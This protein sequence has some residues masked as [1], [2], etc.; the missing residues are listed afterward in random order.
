MC[1]RFYLNL[2]QEG[3]EQVCVPAAATA[4]L[5]A[6]DPH[7]PAAC[8]LKFVYWIFM[9]QAFL[10]AHLLKRTMSAPHQ[11]P[12]RFPLLSGLCLDMHATTSTQDPKQPL[13]DRPLSAA[14]NKSPQKV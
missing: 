7:L 5:A 14:Q 8:D 3:G 11:T 6:L 2:Q 9:K 1:A 4:P 12:A 10:A 13:G